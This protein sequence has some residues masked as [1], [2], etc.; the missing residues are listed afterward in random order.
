MTNT[1]KLLVCTAIMLL[2]F[3]VSTNAQGK[4]VRV[5]NG[6]FFLHGKPYH[7]IGTNMWYGPLLAAQ[8]TAGLMRLRRELDFLKANGV[9]NLR[10]M[11]GA[12]GMH[13][14]DNKIV[15]FS[16]QPNQGV[17][18]QRLL[19]SLDIFLNEIGKRGMYA[20]LYLGNNWD[21]SGGFPQYLA[22]NGNEFVTL[23]NRKWDEY[24]KAVAQFQSCQPCMA[25]FES[26]IRFI[27]GR[28]NSVNGRRY[29]ND[30]SI[31][32]W[33]IANEPRPFTEENIPAFVAWMKR[34]AAFIK[35]LDRNHLLSSGGEGEIGFNNLK[36][37]EEVHSDPNYD[38]ATIHIW[39]KNW[40]WFKG[41]EVSDGFDNVVRNT[42]EYLAKHRSIMHSL[43]KPLVLEEFGYP[44]DG[45][46]FSLD[47]PTTLRDRYY[48]LLFRQIIDDAKNGGALAG[49]NFWT[50]GG[51]DFPQLNHTEW[52][53]GDPLRGDPPQEE[54]GLNGVFTTDKSTWR[55]IKKY[56]EELR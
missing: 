45:H 4:F 15:P 25:A 34:T 49:C 37:F 52:H 24:R 5:K 2:C 14:G 46:S 12:D 36:T 22:W 50:F 13:K 18:N 54:Q 32:A 48:E 39:P 38:Y 11:V 6:Q 9:T 19:R 55:L 53:I 31:M 7:Y 28:T 44:R 10:V 30:P 41:T 20:V 40:S 1:N 43:H 16:L 21:W 27:I 33:Q 51:S 35:S 47:S 26:H 29:V 3:S 8:G 56:N 42:N 17:Y 23:H